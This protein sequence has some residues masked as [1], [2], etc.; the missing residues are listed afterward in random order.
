MSKFASLSAG[1]LARKG[2][3][4]PILTPFAD[5]LLTR[6]GSPDA[7][8]DVRMLTPLNRPRVHTHVEPGTVAKVP[9]LRPPSEVATPVFGTLG[10]RSALEL[11]RE[12]DENLRRISKPLTGDGE[13]VL[14]EEDAVGGHGISCVEPSADELGKSY[15][16]NLRM[17]RPRFVKLKLSSALLRKPVQEI[18]AEALDAWFDKLPPD[19]LGDC[20]CMKTRGD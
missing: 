18:V 9:A 16:V 19:V 8:T 11:A 6:V 2:E 5:Q 3:A 1:L 17:K 20:A 14:D 15:H 12:R 10:R 7:A 13:H 4:E